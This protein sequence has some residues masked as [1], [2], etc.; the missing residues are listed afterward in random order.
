VNLAVIAAILVGAAFLIAGGAKVAAG[1]AWPEQAAGVG[2]PRL[3]VPFVPW[4]EILVGAAL[5]AQLARPAVAGVAVAMLVAFSALLALRLSQGRRPP[6]ACFGRWSAKPL[7]WQ[8]LV[9]N[10]VL[11]ALALV[12]ALA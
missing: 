9:R 7:G 5:C 3:V 11:I 8:D 2:A 1:P 6:C 10:A 12:A 4:L